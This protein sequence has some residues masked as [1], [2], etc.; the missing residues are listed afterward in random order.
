MIQ[1]TGIHF[2]S[3]PR[4]SGPSHQ[5]T[6]W[7]TGS[8]L[9]RA[10]AKC[11]LYE[12]FALHPVGPW[13]EVSGGELDIWSITEL[14]QGLQLRMYT[15][16]ASP[17]ELLTCYD[18]AAM[19]CSCTSLLINDETLI[20]WYVEHHSRLDLSQSFFSYTRQCWIVANQ[21]PSKE[22]RCR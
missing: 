12:A 2:G 18:A 16:E 10:K 22:P 17:L 9:S 11:P 1:H 5:S 4:T 21:V 6:A 13:N 7:L 20:P 8:I 3:P 15:H 14:W 19:A